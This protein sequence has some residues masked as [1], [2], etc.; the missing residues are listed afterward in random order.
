MLYIFTYLHLVDVVRKIVSFSYAVI[1]KPISFIIYNI[2]FNSKYLIGKNETETSSQSVSD[3]FPNLK[4][5]IRSKPGFNTDNMTNVFSCNKFDL[6]PLE[7][8]YFY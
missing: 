7:A 4:L 1:I 3:G 6:K 2:I 8:I 5:S